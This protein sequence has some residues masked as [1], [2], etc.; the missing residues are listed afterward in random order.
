MLDLLLIFVI[1][2]GSIIT[3][4]VSKCW[5]IQQKTKTIT[6]DVLQCVSE[7]A[8]AYQLIRKENKIKSAL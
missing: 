6:L 7:I 4:I 1:I 5:K 8:V 3:Y 2:P